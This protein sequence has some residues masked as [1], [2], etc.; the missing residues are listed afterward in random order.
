MQTAPNLPANG[1]NLQQRTTMCDTSAI[2][3]HRRS[4]EQKT[5][6]SCQALQTLHRLIACVDHAPFLFFCWGEVPA[7]TRAGGTG[8]GGH[9]CLVHNIHLSRPHP[10]FRK[11]QTKTIS[12]N[13]K[14]FLGIPSRW[15]NAFLKLP[16]DKQ[17]LLTKIRRLFFQYFDSKS[18]QTILQQWW[19]HQALL[20]TA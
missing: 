6:E 16:L 7:S 4:K 5:W 19:D 14:T 17:L 9:Q 3:L 12:V 1:T 18:L 11:M 20:E 13:R 15:K 2:H 8:T 10:L